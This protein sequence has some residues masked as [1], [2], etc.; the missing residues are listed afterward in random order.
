MGRIRERFDIKLIAWVILP[1][2]LHWLIKPGEADYS[3]V[4]YSFKK[5]LGAEFKKT[6]IISQG[7]M[8]WQDR[9]WEHT[10]KDDE[11]RERCVEYI[12]FNPVKHGLVKA[13][14]DW[15]HSSFHRYVERGIYPADW[16]DGARIV[17]AGAEYDR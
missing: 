5:G 6:G 17:I 3:K 8:I 10:V 12:H 15:K 11:D 14:G 1:D 9:F 2:H 13:P 7:D 16:A 4:V